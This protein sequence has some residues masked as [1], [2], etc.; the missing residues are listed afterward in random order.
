ML[1][2]S[3]CAWL[4]SRFAP[5]RQNLETFLSGSGEGGSEA[6]ISF[7]GGTH[8]QEKRTPWQAFANQARF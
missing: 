7:I 8:H 3:F 4:R 2:A 5:L 1:E 6:D